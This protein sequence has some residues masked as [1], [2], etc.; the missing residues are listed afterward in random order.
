MGQQF[1]L[2][3][4]TS[5]CATLLVYVTRNFW[6]KYWHLLF[7]K[8]Y[9]DV[10]GEYEVII[11]YREDQDYSDIFQGETTV[12][13]IDQFGKTLSGKVEVRS[14]TK[15]MQVYKLNGFVTAHANI[16]ITYENTSASV[17]GVGAYVLSMNGVENT[18][19]GHVSFICSNCNE[20]HEY[21][22]R[23]KK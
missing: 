23:L 16:V 15:V 7:A 17:R 14:N 13:F 22:I 12:L 18:L 1:V 9:P 8:I 21:A 20:V 11:T 19:D 2:G 3:V 6:V 10:S 5:L 4:V